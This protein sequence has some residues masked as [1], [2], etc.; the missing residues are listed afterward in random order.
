MEGN[1]PLAKGVIDG[2]E[3]EIPFPYEELN[4]VQQEY[5]PSLVKYLIDE[6]NKDV[7]VCAPM[8]SGKTE[9]IMYSLL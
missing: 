5:V 1:P 6:N 8:G 2:K 4:V 7:L 9:G 3:F